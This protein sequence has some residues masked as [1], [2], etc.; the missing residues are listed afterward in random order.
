MVYQ[1]AET[2]LKRVR[3]MGLSNQTKHIQFAGKLRN[4]V[5]TAIDL[6]AEILA[7]V[8]AIEAEDRRRAEVKRVGN[9][10]WK[11]VSNE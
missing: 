2:T 3:L 9:A 1:V 7:S 10:F 11:G 8:E 6:V 4:T 5:D